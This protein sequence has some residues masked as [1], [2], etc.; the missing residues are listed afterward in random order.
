MTLRLWTVLKLMLMSDTFTAKELADDSGIKLP[1][2]RSILARHAYLTEIVET[3]GS[4]RGGRT[5]RL[6]VRDD[7]RMELE[8]RLRDC[9]P[10][11]AWSALK[12]VTS[13][14]DSELPM[15]ISS[16]LNR[17]EAGPL[18]SKERAEVGRIVDELIANG[19][20]GRI[21]V[22]AFALAGIYAVDGAPDANRVGSES[23]DFRRAALAL[24]SSIVR[25]HSE[26]PTV[27][28]KLQGIDYVDHG[29]LPGTSLPDWTHA[30]GLDGE[31]SFSTEYSPRNKNAD[32]C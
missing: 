27:A 11:P 20:R 21:A 18:G 26:F 28:P 6:K 25:G 22:I 10:R 15:S 9:D 31:P 29:G 23:R 12:G 14:A 30:D 2:V 32:P 5:Q 1:T 24:A 16:A 4:G 8:E 7:E 3:E 13:A 17:L 19:P